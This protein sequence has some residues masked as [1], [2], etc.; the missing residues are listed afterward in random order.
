M[1]TQL[2]TVEAT[3]EL[4]RVHPG[5]V[6]RYILEKKLQARKV[7]GQ[8]RVTAADLQA[9]SGVAS[10]AELA[11]QKVADPGARTYPPSDQPRILVSA[12][13]DIQ[14][15][16]REEADRL[17]SSIMAAMNSRDSRE[18]A[19]CDFLFFGEEGRARF[20]LWG[21]PVFI[22]TMMAMF[23]HIVEPEEKP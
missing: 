11:N 3:A 12:V 2:L 20:V 5:T 8:W 9:F 7:G 14:V 17:S 4:L 22:G 6:R 19:R 18:R 15:H 23:G 16:S 13:V 21:S 10:L 1:S